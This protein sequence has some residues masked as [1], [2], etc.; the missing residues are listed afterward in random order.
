MYS[1]YIITDSPAFGNYFQRKILPP[2]ANSSV[3]RTPKCA[4]CCIRQWGIRANSEG[5]MRNFGSL[6]SGLKSCE[7]VGTGTTVR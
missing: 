3:E 4:I 5:G 7:A 6:R 1:E 2:D